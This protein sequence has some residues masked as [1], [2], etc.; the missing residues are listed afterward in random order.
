[1]FLN[2]F[3]IFI[4]SL[5]KITNRKCYLACHRVS[6]HMTLWLTALM[7]PTVAQFDSHSVKVVS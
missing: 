2:A 3:N 6:C 5:L 1:M 4:T 7:W